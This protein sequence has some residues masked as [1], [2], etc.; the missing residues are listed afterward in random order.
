M[1][2]DS[3]MY[4]VTATAIAMLGC[5][6]SSPSSSQLVPASSGATLTAGAATLTIPP[7]ALTHDT[8]VTLREAD[9][10]HAGRTT[11]VEVQ[12]HDTLA[13]GHVA[14]LSVKM[15]DGNVRV[16]MHH[17]ADDSLADVE[18]DDRNHHA[19]K[20]KMNMLGDIEVEV[21]HGTACAT[22]CASGQECDDGT[23]QDHDPAAHTCGTVCPVGNECDDGTCK[24]HDECAM[25]HHG[26]PGACSP[27]CAT[28][29]TC[30]DGICSAHE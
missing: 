14:L 7:G 24:T 15:S 28:G 13:P 11:R 3:G 4:I 22:T 5:G 29:L 21:E 19:F 8:N 2:L 1:K 26:T 12:P 30:H 9:P 10:Q 20:T 25:E 27:A 17:A 18:V 23:C 16:R 6:S